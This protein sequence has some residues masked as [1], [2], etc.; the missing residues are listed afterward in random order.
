M[1]YVTFELSDDA[2]GVTAL[3]AMASTRAEQHPAVM[4]EV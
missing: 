1:R 2:E 4:A 3:D